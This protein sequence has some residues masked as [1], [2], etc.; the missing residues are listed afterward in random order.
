MWGDIVILSELEL[1]SEMESDLD[2]LLG[3][4]MESE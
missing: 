3:F 2:Q 4:A 1:G